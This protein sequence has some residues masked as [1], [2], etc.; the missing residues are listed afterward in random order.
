[1]TKEELQKRMLNNISDD[2]D[3]SEG[4]FFCDAVTP[5][6][7]E[8][9]KS[10]GEQ[11]KILEHVFVETAT[12]DYLTRKCAEMGI[13]RKQ[14]TKATGQVEITGT[15]AAVVPQGTLV[16]TEL[17]TFETTK[18][19]TL[20]NTGKVTVNVECKQVGAVG[21]VPANS[22]KYFP[23]TLE[24]LDKV[25]NMEPFTG[26]YDTEI[27]EQLRERF[28]EK[29]NEPPTSGN[30]AHYK[31]WAKEVQGVG[32]AK[33]FPLWNGNGTVKV[34]VCD[35]EARAASAELIGEV[36]THIEVERPIG[37]AVTVESA[38]EKAINVS[39]KITLIHGRTLEQVKTDL[40]KSLVEMF[41]VIAFNG[42]YVSYAKIGALLFDM[43]GVGDYSDLLINGGTE[44]IPLYDVEIPTFGTVVLT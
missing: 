32:D 30:V 3:K 36:S 18:K 8:L 33:I 31:M 28:Y 21:N 19:T 27:D 20:D 24:G 14:A 40:E 25:N 38:T 17:V 5:V 15:A 35:A 44:N 16:A 43:Y 37:A 41:K 22:V 13:N 42:A 23:V 1:M 29:V 7:T 34:V 12:D 39:A 9:S 10:Y 2:Y 26:G 6:A 4:S 11:D